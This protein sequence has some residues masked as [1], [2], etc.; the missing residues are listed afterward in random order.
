LNAGASYEWQNRPAPAFEYQLTGS[1]SGCEQLFLGSKPV[2]HGL[3]DCASLHLENSKRQTAVKVLK[4]GDSV[5][6]SLW[7][8]LFSKAS[9]RTAITYHLRVRHGHMTVF[10][11]VLR[12]TVN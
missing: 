9:I 12:H 10:G 3:G 11:G 1:D 2:A 8:F 5:R 7:L 6:D 4:S